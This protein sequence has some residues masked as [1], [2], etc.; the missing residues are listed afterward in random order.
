MKR[1]GLG[2]AFWV[3]PFDISGDIGALNSIALSRAQQ[4][5]SGLD[6]DGTERIPLRSD[7]EMS[8]T[9]FW[10]A[11][12]DRSVEVLNDLAVPH[13]QCTY[14]PGRGVG[15]YTA[16]LIANRTTVTPTR[17]QDGSPVLAGQVMGSTGTKLE[18]GRLL[19]AGRQTWVAAGPAIDD[20]FPRTDQTESE[21][22]FSAYLHVF[23]IA[24]GSPEVYVE[25][26]ANG[27]DWDALAAF[28]P[29]DSPT[30]ERIVAT[31]TVRRYVRA[32]VTAPGTGLVLAV[33]FVRH[34]TEQP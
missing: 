28:T 33:S 6:V 23:A 22:G 9:G 29:T 24:S 16:S 12:P 11:A 34:L 27:A 17:G 1:S 5:V 21:W 31:G 18:W 14:A 3:G 4:D 7:G 20:H 13:L 25:D 26:S 10:N 2:S 19:T 15:D 8:Y 30:A 32:A